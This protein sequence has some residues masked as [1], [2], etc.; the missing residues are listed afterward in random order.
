MQL[1]LAKGQLRDVVSE[2]TYM[3]NTK[4]VIACSK[5]LILRT[6]FLNFRVYSTQTSH[7]NTGMPHQKPTQTQKK[8]QDTKM[9]LN[10]S[11]AASVAG[12]S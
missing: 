6:C 4:E 5:Q 11:S 12:R 9:Q 8:K 3:A 7:E 10:D 1:V 2:Y